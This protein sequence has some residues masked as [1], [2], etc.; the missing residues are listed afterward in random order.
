MT[1]SDNSRHIGWIDYAKSFAIYSVVLLHTHC[2][3][4]LSVA[5]NGYVM[6]LFFFLSGFL[7][8][9]ERNPRFRSFLMK[10]FRQLIVPY[11]WINAVAYILW[12]T[13]LRKF[14]TDAGDALQW[15]EPLWG[16]LL[17][18]PPA[19]AHDIPL[20]SILCFFVVEMIYY[21]LPANGKWNDLIIA[22]C[23]WVAASAISLC[24]GD[25]G[26][27]LPLTLAP[28]T[29]AL[30][31]YALGHF[32]RRHSD[33][34]RLIFSPSPAMLLLGLGLLMAGVSLN[35]PTAFFLGILGNPLS[36]FIGAVG[37]IITGIQIAAWLERIFHD[38]R[39]I[40]LISR[41]TLIICGFH[42]LAFAFIKGVMLFGFGIQPEALTSSLPRGILFSVAATTLCLPLIYAIER[43]ARWLVSK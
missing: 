4:S 38:G 3:E 18:I 34:A 43:W 42:L 9:R 22:A 21:L 24:A 25:E 10:R 19:L 16:I 11:L 30:T 37:G 40:R 12:L 13:V 5:I 32:V 1:L 14:G 8:S 15:H 35:S 27:A 2:V 23:A 26:I 28:A 6:P 29:G 36:F 17:G 7:F 39:L 41:G 31:F 33:T 20:W